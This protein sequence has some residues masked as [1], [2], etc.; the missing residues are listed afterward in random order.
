VLVAEPGDE[1]VAPNSNEAPAGRLQNGVLTIQ[2]EAAMGEWYPEESDGPAL[3]VAALREEGGRLSTPG[4]LLRVPE[5]TQIHVTV[6]SWLDQLLTLH[7]LHSRPGDTK[8][9]LVVPSGERR[10]DNFLEGAPGAYFYW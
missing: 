6:H 9:V 3:K 8:D 5:G 4:P 2:L 7:G 10:E 1:R